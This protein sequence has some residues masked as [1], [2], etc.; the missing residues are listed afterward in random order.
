M[1]LEPGGPWGFIG[2]TGEVI[3]QPQ[4]ESDRFAGGS[5]FGPRFSEG[6]AAVAVEDG[7]G[8]IDKTGAW[9]IEPQYVRAL[10]FREGLALAETE[11]EQTRHDMWGLIDKTGAWVVEPQFR[12]VSSFSDG[13]WRV[14]GTWNGEGIAIDRTGK[15]VEEPASVSGWLSAG[16][17]LSVASAG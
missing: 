7:Y 4:F 17:T 1:R 12:A 2:E 13:I 9:V 5:P 11:D 6:L 15:V 14:G 8:Y 3:I 16:G 10:E